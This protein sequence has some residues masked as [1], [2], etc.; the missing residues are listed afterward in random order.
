MFTLLLG[1]FCFKVV[2]FS[3]INQTLRDRGLKEVLE[4]DNIGIPLVGRELA[5]NHVDESFELIN[6]DLSNLLLINV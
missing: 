6:H 4:R 2:S 3:F 1:H 5:A